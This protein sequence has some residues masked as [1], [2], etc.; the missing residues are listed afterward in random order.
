MSN[1]QNL[2]YYVGSLIVSL[3]G[4]IL[5]LV[6]D[7]AGWSAYNY[8]A[9]IQ[10]WGWVGFNELPAGLIFLIPAIFLF[11]CTWISI[12]ALRNPN[13]APSKNSILLGF[14]LSLVVFIIAL[15]GGIIFVLTV[16]DV[17]DWWFGEAFYG[18]L[19]GGGI[20]SLFFHI[21]SKNIN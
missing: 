19:L 10:S 11:Y 13:M 12:Q 9:G 3:I 21:A 14:K 18:G 8:Y 6:T 7:F 17:S 20:T 1:N 15:I 4:G 16:G 2:S 5:L